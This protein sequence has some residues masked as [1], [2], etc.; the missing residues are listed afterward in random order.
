MVSTFCEASKWS[1]P[2][3]QPR[4]RSLKTL[5]YWLPLEPFSN[6]F[7]CAALCTR[8][9]EALLSSR[10][11]VNILYYDYSKVWSTKSARGQEKC[12]LLVL[13][14]FFKVIVIIFGEPCP[15][16]RVGLQLFNNSV[17]IDILWSIVF[18]HKD[19]SATF[20]H[21]RGVIMHFCAIKEANWCWTL[22]EILYLCFYWSVVIFFILLEHCLRLNLVCF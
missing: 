14:L 13:V 10:L 9:A 6:Y 7:T 15:F 21:R 11:N 12:T 17:N 8:Q 19:A 2:C 3:W 1:F 4:T 20:D 16:R 22:R 18:C 5:V